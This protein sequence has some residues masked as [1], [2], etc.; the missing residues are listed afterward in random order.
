[1]RELKEKR[2]ERR[3]GRE[4]RE[5][6]ISIHLKYHLLLLIVFHLFIQ[7]P[8]PPAPEPANN[9]PAASSPSTPSSSSDAPLIPGA[10]N[11]I[12]KEALRAVIHLSLS[13]F[14]FLSLLL[15]LRSFF[16]PFFFVSIFYIL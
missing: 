4:G 16:P 15:S 9:T 7:I 14:S 13:L 12:V 1:M 3:E 2:G 8:A 11:Y 10:M 6:T 5:I